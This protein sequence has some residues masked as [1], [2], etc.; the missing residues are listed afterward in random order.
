MKVPNLIGKFL[1]AMCGAA[2]VAYSAE[3]VEVSRVYA[4]MGGSGSNPSFISA[5]SG[6]QHNPIGFSSNPNYLSHAGFRHA[7][8]L[9]S[10]VGD[11][12]DNDGLP[13]WQELTGISYY[14]IAPSGINTA[15]SDGDGHTDSVEITT[16]T[17]P[18]NASSSLAMLTVSATPSGIWLQWLGRED[19]T[20]QILTANTVGDLS[21]N[22]QLI[23]VH[24]AT[25][26]SGPWL[27]SVCGLTADMST[28]KQ[29][30]TVKLIP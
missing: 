15:D 27:Q 9:A 16:G 29:Y 4:G 14:P 1:L 7:D 20:Y 3:L 28:I 5:N 22:A 12:S 10:G 30:F 13:D 11:D 6:V 24:V 21:T 23:A 17:D 19:K 2:S 8:G 18:M 26:G 25:N